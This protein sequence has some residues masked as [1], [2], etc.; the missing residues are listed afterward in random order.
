[1]ESNS[2]RCSRQ[3][4]SLLRDFSG[5]VPT[6]A[7]LVGV[8]AYSQ[9][10]RERVAAARAELRSKVAKA[11]RCVILQQQAD[12]LTAHN[13]CRGGTSAIPCHHSS[14]ERGGRPA[15]C[16][17]TAVLP[18]YRL[19]FRPPGSTKMPAAVGWVS[20]FYHP[21]TPTASAWQPAANQDCVAFC[22][23]RSAAY[24]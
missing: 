1:M 4:V 17:T 24:G 2:A 23:G 5:S 22:S 13:R 8:P 16:A 3:W 6:L 15:T 12:T 11:A 14:P 19:D 10:L 9:D 7:V 20:G 21:A 18:Y